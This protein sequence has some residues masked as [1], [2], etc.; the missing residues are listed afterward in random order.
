MKELTAA[1]MEILDGCAAAML[2]GQKYHSVDRSLLERAE[3]VDVQEAIVA[4]LAIAVF[5]QTD[6]HWTVRRVDSTLYAREIPGCLNVATCPAAKAEGPI[7][8]LG[9]G[10]ALFTF[11]W[12]WHALKRGSPATVNV[13]AKRRERAA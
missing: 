3:S 10:M 6:G 12:A 13:V 11:S 4:F 7:T 2:R 8:K 5:Y 1:E 9:T